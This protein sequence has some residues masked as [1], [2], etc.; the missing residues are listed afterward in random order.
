MIFAKLKCSWE[1]TKF[2]MVATIASQ[3]AGKLAIQK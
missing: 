1:A 2:N 3:L